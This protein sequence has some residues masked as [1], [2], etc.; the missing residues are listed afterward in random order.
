MTDK[1]LQRY[2][3]RA[4]ETADETDGDLLDNLGVFGWLG[5]P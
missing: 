5:G 4:G 1:V 2:T 3:T